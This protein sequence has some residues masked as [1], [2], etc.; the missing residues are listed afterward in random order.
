M[1][2]L[3]RYDVTIPKLIELILKM[4]P[5][6]R[7]WLLNEVEQTKIKLRAIRRNCCVASLLNYEGKAYPATITNL[8][9]TGAFVE[10]YIPVRIG[11]SVSVEFIDMTGTEKIKLNARIVHAT[12]S[13]C[14]IQYKTVRSSAARFLQKC[15][16]DFRPESMVTNMARSL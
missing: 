9:F 4:T 3:R 11:D 1:L 15:L 12:K 10:C 2:K 5:D 14:G 16:D 8:S 13:G 7:S 6:E